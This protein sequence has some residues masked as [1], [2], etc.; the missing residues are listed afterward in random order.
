M[1]APSGHKSWS[2]DAQRSS[3]TFSLGHSHLGPIRGEFRCWGGQVH[4]DPSGDGQPSV[5]VWVD[6]SSLDTGSRRLDAAIL[7]SELFDIQ[8]QPALVFDGDK[9]ERTHDAR[10]VLTGWLGLHSFR[11]QI[12]IDVTLQGA[13]EPDAEFVATARATIDRRA[14]GLR[15]GKRARGWLSERLVANNI[16]MNAEVVAQPATYAPPARQDGRLAGGLSGRLAATTLD[17]PAA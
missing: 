16:E 15:R 8:W 13:A 14:L 9:L 17:R 11:K 7:D 2:I 1:F 4:L 3:L 6:L 5:H 10:A 12:S